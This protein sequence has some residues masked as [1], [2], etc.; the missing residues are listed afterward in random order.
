VAG[1]F[2]IKTGDQAIF[3]PTFPPA[4]VVAAPGVITGSGQATLDGAMVCV[5][6]DE[7]SVV[8][9]GVSYVSPP[10]AIPGVGTL[11]IAA[12]GP[13]QVAQKTTYMK[14]PAI[15]KGSK[16]TARFSVMVP[17]M[18]ATPG[19]PVPD[20]VAVYTGTGTF[21]TTNALSTGS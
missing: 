19:G 12:L 5:Q 17:A 10:F 7:A 21:V 3:N 9:A 8:V 16:F 13:D 18:Q 11:T 2:I 6:W 4:T 15:L 14:K 20:P 1:D